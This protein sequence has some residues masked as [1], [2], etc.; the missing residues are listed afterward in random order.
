MEISNYTEVHDTYPKLV[1][2]YWVGK[3]YGIRRFNE[4]EGVER[5]YFYPTQTETKSSREMVPL[6]YSKPIYVDYPTIFGQLDP[7]VSS[8]YQL[9]RP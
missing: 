7:I 9:N 5:G 8:Y 3:Y 2:D 6:K 1:T 4:N